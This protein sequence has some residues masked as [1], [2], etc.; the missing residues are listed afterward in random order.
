MLNEERIRLMTRIARYEQNEGRRDLKI[1]KYYRRDY[2]GIKLLKN[3]FIV[4][5]GYGLIL[6]LIFGYHIEYLLDNIHKMDL[7]PLIAE[8]IIGYLLVMV[9]Y[10]VITYTVCSVNWARA[11]KSVKSYY[12]KLSELSVL[13][14]REEKRQRNKNNG[15]D[16]S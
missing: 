8:V 12:A 2:L 10:M 13:Y 7:Q 11:K 3:F 14:T 6:I 9:F 5:I 4:T 15:R 16:R 1:S